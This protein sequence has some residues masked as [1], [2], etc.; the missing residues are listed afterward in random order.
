MKFFWGILA[1]MPTS[2][3]PASTSKRDE[4][5]AV[6][7]NFK[8]NFSLEAM[9]DEPT[10]FVTE[11]Y[12]RSSSHQQQRPARR[13]MKVQRHGGYLI[14]FIDAPSKKK[15]GEKEEVEYLDP[16]AAT[17]DKRKE[18][19]KMKNKNRKKHGSNTH[20]N[21]EIDYASDASSV[22]DEYP[23]AEPNVTQFNATYSDFVTGGG[24]TLIHHITNKV[25]DFDIPHVEDGSDVLV[26]AVKPANFYTFHH[27]EY[28]AMLLCYLKET[29]IHL[30]RNEK[31]HPVRTYNR[32][33]EV[34]A[35]VP[36]YS[37]YDVETSQKDMETHFGRE[38][39]RDGKPK[40][41]ANRNTFSDINQGCTLS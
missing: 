38:I 33:N 19:K 26:L 25:G 15:K 30:W 13:V 21:N 7:S 6:Q 2:I 34:D 8:Q 5:A 35:T 9:E 23:H 27:Y 29:D 17:Y 1:L 22:P 18:R 36:H 14:G 37:G 31:I 16:R 32:E 11:E 10:Q 39:G 12:E 41:F 20:F 24:T 28:D 3:I 40:L 4:V